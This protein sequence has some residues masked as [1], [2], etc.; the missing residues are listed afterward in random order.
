MPLLVDMRRGT[1]GRSEGCA[2]VDECCRIG[3][4]CETQAKTKNNT[5]KQH[6]LLGKDDSSPSDA[7][8]IIFII[9]SQYKWRQWRAERQADRETDQLYACP[10]DDK[11]REKG[12]KR[13]RQGLSLKLADQRPTYA[14]NWQRITKKPLVRLAPSVSVCL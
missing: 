2:S 4:C 11:E 14:S 7:S 1:K 12:N 5:R 10:A 9:I 6:H 13:E 8:C 3:L